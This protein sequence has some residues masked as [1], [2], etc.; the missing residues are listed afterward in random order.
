MIGA[1]IGDIA[2]STFEFD[3]TS[4]YNF[5]LFAAGSEYTDDSI[6]TIAI[7][8]AILKGKD[9]GESLVKWCRKYPDPMG[10]YGGGFERWLNSAEQKPYGSW[11]NGAAMRVAA[12]GWAFN[13]SAEVRREAMKSAEIT[14]NHLEGLIGAVATALAI[15]ECRVVKGDEFSAKQIIRAIAT[16]YYGEDYR[17]RLPRPGK[18]EAGCLGTVDTALAVIEDSVSF[19]DAIRKAVARGGDSDTLGAIVGGIAEAI[20]DIPERLRAEAMEILPQDLRSV[21]EE[22]EKK[23]GK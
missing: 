5:D 10:A 12:V 16:E 13:S 3:N 22:F 6:C 19:E 4:D 21:V 11:G 14:H 2:G 20:W 9:Y 17:E 15:Y 8:D 23:Y 18:F 1:I 7:A